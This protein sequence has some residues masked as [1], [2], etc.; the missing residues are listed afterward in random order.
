MMTRIGVS[1]PDHDPHPDR[2][3]SRRVYPNGNVRI[4][5]PQGCQYVV[6]VV[7]TVV[8]FLVLRSCGL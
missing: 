3:F 6:V 5:Y 8:V 4:Y 7:V 2:P 1:M